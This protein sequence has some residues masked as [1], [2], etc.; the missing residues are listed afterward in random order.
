MALCGEIVPPVVVT[1]PPSG[2]GQGPCPSCASEGHTSEGGPYLQFPKEG[3]NP[4]S[5]V[6]IFHTTSHSLVPKAREGML[7]SPFCPRTHS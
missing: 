3:Q 6:V 1:C 4:S 2:S 7:I 5:G